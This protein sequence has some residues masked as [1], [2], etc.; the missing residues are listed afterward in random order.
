MKEIVDTGYI[1]NDT[2]AFY[3]FIIQEKS[4]LALTFPLTTDTDNNVARITVQCAYTIYNIYIYIYNIYIQKRS[5]DSQT[6]VFLRFLSLV[7]L[8]TVF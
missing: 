6:D 5:L 3:S 2:F 4:F 1:P 8:G 7:F